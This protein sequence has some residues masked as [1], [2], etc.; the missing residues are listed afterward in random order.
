[1]GLERYEKF[2]HAKE[3][4]QRRRVGNRPICHCQQGSC[5]AAVW[6]F[7]DQC[8]FVTEFAYTGDLDFV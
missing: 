8:I 4:P 3:E 5:T 2:I 1:M 7:I 6:A